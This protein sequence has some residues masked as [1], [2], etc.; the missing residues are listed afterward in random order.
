[1]F[2]P[3]SA[4]ARQHFPRTPGLSSMVTVNSFAFAVR[5][6]LLCVQ[7]C[8]GRRQIEQF[9]ARVHPWTSRRAVTRGSF[10]GYTFARIRAPLLPIIPA[11]ER[12]FLLLEY[13]ED[14]PCGFAPGG[15]RFHRPAILTTGSR[16]PSR[17][18]RQWRC[19][20]LRNFRPY[21]VVFRDG[22]LEAADVKSIVFQPRPDTGGKPRVRFLAMTSGACF[23]RDA[24]LPAAA[25]GEAPA[26]RPLPVFTAKVEPITCPVKTALPPASCSN[27]GSSPVRK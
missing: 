24:Y 11:Q 22:K 7:V 13:G 16:G 19:S 21:P 2:T 4:R 23:R 10:P 8:S 5:R 3:L 9:R 20:E 26:M 15:S 25:V 14:R 27:M 12:D 18:R 6:R 17:R 1:M